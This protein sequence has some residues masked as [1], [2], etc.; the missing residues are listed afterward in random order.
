M[1]DQAFEEKEFPGYGQRFMRLALKGIGI[2]GLSFIGIL[3]GHKTDLKLLEY[4]AIAG[5]LLGSLYT[6]G[7]LTWVLRHVNCPSCGRHCE[8]IRDVQKNQWKAR[9]EACHTDWKLGVGTRSSNP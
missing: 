1:T 9:C 4:L 5:F 2:T 7:Y 6:L 3:V 8:S